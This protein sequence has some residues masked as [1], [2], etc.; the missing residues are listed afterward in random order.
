VRPAPLSRRAQADLRQATE[1]IAL[2][3]PTAAR[4][5]RQAV[6]NAAVR[7][8][9]FPLIGRVRP[10]LI[11]SRY[12][13][14]TLTPFPYLLIYNAERKRPVIVRVVHGARDLSTVLSDL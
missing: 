13:F 2:E 5:L 7:I 3:N 9:E 14:L 4:G 8:G 1:W 12:R 11:K 10:E 6:A